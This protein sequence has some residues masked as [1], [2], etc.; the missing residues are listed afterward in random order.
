[1]LRGFL[2]LF[3]SLVIPYGFYHFYLVSNGNPIAIYSS[4]FYLFTNFFCYGAS[5]LFH[6]IEWSHS[7]EILMQKIDH[8][9]IALLSWGTF[10][11]VCVLLMAYPYGIIFA[12]ML[13]LTCSYCCY[14]IMYSRPSVLRQAL[15]PACLVPFIP[16]LYTIMTQYEFYCI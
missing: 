15:V 6:T 11:P 9:G 8:C 5:G 14:N 7:A 3:L 4:F 13:F 16:Y 12:S 10:M 1:M 2:H